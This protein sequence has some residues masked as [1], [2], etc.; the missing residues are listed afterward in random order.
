[1]GADRMEA[2]ASRHQ[3]HELKV[4][5]L[6]QLLLHR[7]RWRQEGRS[8]VWTNGC[9]DLL[10]VGHVRSLQEA[11][12]L[13]DVL[14]VGINSDQSVRRLKGPGRPLVPDVERAE[15]L[16]ALECVDRVLIFEEPTPAPILERLQPDI[17][18]KGAEYAPPHGKPVPEAAVVESYGGRIAFLSMAPAISTTELVR[19]VREQ[20]VRAMPIRG[21]RPAVFLDR[22]GTLIEDMD[23]PRDPKEVRLL[24]GCAAALATLKNRGFAL[25]VV[26]N[27]SGIGRGLILPEQ[28]EAVHRRFAEL[29]AENGVEADAVYYCPHA[30]EEECACR[31]PSPEVLLRAAR[32]LDLCLQ[33]SFM[34]GDKSSDVEA[35]QRAGCRAILLRDG[36]YVTYCGTSPD[37]VAANWDEVLQYV[38]RQSME[39]A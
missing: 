8:V 34:V 21:S 12:S 38:A 25:V 4:F 11:R 19:R 29:L 5:G 18:C 33:K 24:P 16:A 2:N 36:S 20:A 35:G 30:P 13:G 1:M 39:K 9:F 10:H 27:Q 15:I 26:S 23:Y 7:Q 31:K 17:H 22:D 37:R 6:D 32:E 14:L 28:A 3:C